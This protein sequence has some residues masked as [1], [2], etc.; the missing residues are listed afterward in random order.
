[1]KFLDFDVVS[2]NVGSL[3]R[4]IVCS[5]E[6][7]ERLKSL[8]CINPHSYA[9]ALGDEGFFEAIRSSNCVVVDGIGVKICAKIFFRQTLMRI[10]GYDVFINLM[11]C[12]NGKQDKRVFFL[13]SDEKTLC[14][15][16]QKVQREY[17]NVVIAGMYSPPF[18]D[19]FSHDDVR[20]IAAV[21]NRYNIDALW[22]GLTAPKQE[23]LIAQLKEHCNFKW[24]FAV[25]A[26][27]DYYSGLLYRP[28]PV[29]RFFGLEWLFR[30]MQQP[31]KIGR[32]L[33]V[34]N[35]KFI[36]YCWRNFFFGSSLK[37]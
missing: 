14:L 25:G 26:V 19:K 6:H 37:R 2:E 8:T 35:T 12:M 17:P 30:L 23:K 4:K 7:G 33:F 13:G 22:V 34:S 18:K 28:H 31:N 11:N 1:M 36:I 5:M 24:A 15:I 21:L 29:I 3:A 9:V 10:T 20:K 32:R 16:Q 27:F